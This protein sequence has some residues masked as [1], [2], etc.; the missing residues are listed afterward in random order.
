MLGR[1]GRRVGGRRNVG[2]DRLKK[3]LDVIAFG[4]FDSDIERD[5]STLVLAITTLNL[6]VDA[7]LNL[8]LEN[9]GSLRL[10]ETNH[11]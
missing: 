7:L 9:T 1:R 3:M 6:F 10:V 8:S 11:F 2:G 5:P 4:E